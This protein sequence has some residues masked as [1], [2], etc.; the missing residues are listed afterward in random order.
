MLRLA[1]PYGLYYGVRSNYVDGAC[2][3]AVARQTIVLQ[4]KA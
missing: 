4:E 2:Y 3:G 1:A